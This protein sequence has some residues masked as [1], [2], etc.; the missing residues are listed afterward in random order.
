MLIEA[1]SNGDSAA[2]LEAIAR[3]E[4]TDVGDLYQQAPKFDGPQDLESRIKVSNG[5][6]DRLI[7]EMKSRLTEAE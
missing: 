2:A 6:R 7:R 5:L 3:L 1:I 4:G